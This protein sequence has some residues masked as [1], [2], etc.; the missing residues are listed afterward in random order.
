M[1]PLEVTMARTSLEPPSPTPK[2]WLCQGIRLHGH[3]SRPNSQRWGNVMITA[4]L[5]RP[6]QKAHV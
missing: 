1:W 4:T 2:V 5:K 3:L 6:M